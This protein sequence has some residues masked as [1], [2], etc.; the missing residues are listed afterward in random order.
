MCKLWHKGMTSGQEAICH[1]YEDINERARMDVVN[2]TI[3]SALF[4]CIAIE[5]ENMGRSY[6]I[7]PVHQVR[8]VG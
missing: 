8:P 5:I 6:S 3:C 1:F 4:K 2:I 7:L